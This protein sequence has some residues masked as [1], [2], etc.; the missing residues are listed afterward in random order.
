MYAKVFQQIFDSSIADD[1][2]LRHFFMD[3]LVLA[4]SDGV[5]DMTPSA[6]AAR[7]RIPLEEV[8]AHL[9]R[10]EEPDT[11][12]RTPDE[13]GRRIE[14][15]DEHRSWGWHIINY[16][17]FREIASEEQ[18]K[19]KTRERVRKFREKRSCNAPVTHSNA[20][21]RGGNDSPSPSPY[22]SSSPCTGEGYG[23]GYPTLPMALAWSA[24]SNKA[25]S[26]YSAE[27]TKAAFLALA[28]NGWMWGKNRVADW[29]AAIETKIN[30]RREG[31]GG[32]VKSPSDI[33]TVIQAKESIALALK[34]KH[35]S[36]VAMGTTWNDQKA[37]AEYFNLKKEIKQLNQKLGAMA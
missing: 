33:K 31:K 36:E 16:H 3:L 9:K 37:K 23:E 14:R 34:Q 17:K 13:N 29:R 10:L 11:E 28:A 1:H 15:L 5:V 32:G 22:P 4:D 27:E 26:D 21:L 20:V 2:R 24:E 8:V 6:I 7:T 30:D 25:G 18:R 12:S 35:S 19:S